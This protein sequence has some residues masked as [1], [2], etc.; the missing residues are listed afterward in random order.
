MA[1][2]LGLIDDWHNFFNGKAEEISG[3]LAEPVAADQASASCVKS[4]L[5]GC[6]SLFEESFRRMEDELELLRRIIYRHKSQMRNSLHLRNL[7]Q[8]RKACERLISG[9]LRQLLNQAIDVVSLDAPCKSPSTELI[10]YMM[11]RSVSNGVLSLRLVARAEMS[12][13][14]CEELIKNA[15]FMPFAIACYAI[16][17]RIRYLAKDIS[18]N[19][20]E[21]HLRLSVLTSRVR[22]HPKFSGKTVNE[23]MEALGGSRWPTKYEDQLNQ[24]LEL[25]NER[26][27]RDVKVLSEA[28]EKD[29][30]AAGES[31]GREGSV[32]EMSDNDEGVAIEF[33]AA[34]EHTTAKGKESK[35]KPDK[36]ATSKD[37]ASDMKKKRKRE[38]EQPKITPE[39]VGK[40]AKAKDFGG[41]Q[42][43]REPLE[44]QKK[45]QPA[46]KKNMLD[47]LMPVRDTD[48]APTE[49]KCNRDSPAKG[50]SAEKSSVQGKLKEKPQDK[51]KTGSSGTSKKV[52]SAS[53]AW[54]LMKQNSSVATLTKINKVE[55]GKSKVAEKVEKPKGFKSPSQ[56][57]VA[58]SAQAKK[59]KGGG[60][61]IFDSLMP[62]SEWE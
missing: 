31:K 35:P 57:D 34:V 7:S 44:S 47:S 9:G 6:V 8:M 15:L 3:N 30:L 42:K 28:N 50:K 60:G 45:N 55:G 59:P 17:A 10:E 22:K 51:V 21:A 40:K 14:S 2:H 26:Q 5:E 49:G 41:E 39:S 52:V 20:V 56:A 4:V 16:S 48:E 12:F 61:G 25:L 27:V 19:L 53:S 33:S 23:I 1:D 54:Q 13:L 29:I 43:K 62:K 37:V 46:E 38:M 11:A 32:E 58:K 36:V 18:S 24:L